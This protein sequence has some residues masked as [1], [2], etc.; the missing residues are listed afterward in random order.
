LKNYFRIFI[1]QRKRIS[2]HIVIL[3]IA[4]LL[5]LMFASNILIQLIHKD[6]QFDALYANAYGLMDSFFGEEETNFFNSDEGVPKIKAFYHK[7][8]EEETFDYGVM[9]RQP[10][11]IA[12]LNLGTS[13]YDG[14]GTSSTRPTELL[15]DNVYSSIQ[16]N[17]VSLHRSAIDLTEGRFFNEEEY[18]YEAGKQLPVLIGADFKTYFDI[19]DEINISYLNREMDF[20][21]VGILDEDSYIVDRNHFTVFLNKHFVL[22]AIDIVD[23]FTGVGRTFQQ[24]VY[25]QHTNGI[26]YSDLAPIAI[27]DK[28]QRF[29][30]EL[31]LEPHYILLNVPNINLLGLET[32]GIVVIFSI[33]SILL[34][35]VSI[36]ITMLN[37][38]SKTDIMMKNYAVHYISG[39][40][41]RTLGSFIMLEMIVSFILGLMM[42]FLSQ[43]FLFRSNPTNWYLITAILLLFVLTPIPSLVKI[44]NMNIP[45]EMRR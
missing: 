23:D 21:V 38:L 27:V 16:V 22:P 12:D 43:Y 10:V 18:L 4:S 45:E 20:V 15:N 11:Y 25:L 28:I 17:N 30:N 19:G 33:I 9:T 26:I 6:E 7:L 44:A 36:I 32:R 29:S 35:M 14:Y 39:A 2:N 13:Y 8:N 34:L 42:V 41:K 40:R 1:T 3:T 37:L 5:V 24:R 31:G